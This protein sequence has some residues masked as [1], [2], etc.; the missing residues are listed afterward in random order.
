[1][2]GVAGAA[3]ISGGLGIAGSFIGGSSAKKA[4]QAQAAQ[5]AA[6][7][8]ENR[9]Q[10]NITQEN[11]APFLG[12]GQGAI[13]GLIQGSTIGGLDER[14]GQVFEGQGFQNLLQDRTR[15]AQSGLAAGGLT[16]SGA[17]VR[18]IADVSTG[19][20]LELEGLLTGRLGNLAGIGQNAAVAQGGFGQNFAQSQGQFLSSLGQTQA[21]G[22]L[23]QGQADAA[24]NQQLLQGLGGL[25][26]GGIGLFGGGGGQTATPQQFS[27][28]SNQVAGS[29][30]PPVFPTG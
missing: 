2:P 7:L 5:Q 28:V 24:R 30:I 16:R 15:A 21:Q 10:F 11:L 27:D 6:A 20:G 4:A 1:M 12:A 25:I 23:G 29:F 22:I 19:L 8:A 13:P 9:R 14:L 3:A 26:S 17:G 18:G